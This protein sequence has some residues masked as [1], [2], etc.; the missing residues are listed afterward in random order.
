MLQN[1]FFQQ[2]DAYGH[3]FN[4]VNKIAGR[5]FWRQQGKY[6]TGSGHQSFDRPMI[7]VAL[8]VYIDI[9]PCRLTG[10]YSAQ[11]SFP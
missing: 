11:V 1:L 8:P 10:S 9:N 3:A 5:V 6:A 2:S 4:D 7:R